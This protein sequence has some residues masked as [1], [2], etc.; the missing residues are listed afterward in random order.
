MA[1]KYVVF[2]IIATLGFVADQA[3]KWW[4]ANNLEVHTDE[5]VLIPK[6][7]SIVHAQ[8]TGAAFSSL[9]GAWPL[10]FVFFALVMSVAI[11]D[12]LRRQAPTERAVPFALAL[13]I[14]GALGNGLDRITRGHVVDMIKNYAGFEPAKSWFIEQ[15]RT[16][17]WPIYNIAD[18]MLLIGVAAFLLYFLFQGESEPQ[19][20]DLTTPPGPG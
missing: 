7:M 13:I 1:P 16:N 11:L 10:M 3:T 19:G 12:L 9:D 2:S 17:V 4:V 14:A 8:N 18:S 15:F 5:I 20:D 6:F